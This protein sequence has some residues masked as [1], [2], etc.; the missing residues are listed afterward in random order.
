MMTILKKK[1][2]FFVTV[3]LF[4]C[5]F[6]KLLNKSYFRMPLCVACNRNI[7]P[8]RDE[9][10]RL[11]QSKNRRA[12]FARLMGIDVDDM[13]G[14]HDKSLLCP[15][16]FSEDA[17]ERDNYGRIASLKHTALP[18]ENAIHLVPVPLRHEVSYLLKITLV[19][20]KSFSRHLTFNH[21]CL[22]TQRIMLL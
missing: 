6:V 18:V 13:Q 20:F 7:D 5:F 1:T 12:I 14:F 17:F 15:Q 16:H 8:G 4:L 22:V 10:V 3:F 19:V 11:P 2:N 9:S 21:V